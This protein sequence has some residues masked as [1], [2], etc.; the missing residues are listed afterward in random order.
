MPAKNRTSVRMRRV[1][2]ELRRLRID[3]KIPGQTV[4]RKLGVS[5]SKISRMENFGQG[6]TR[7]A[8][9]ELL[10]L[11]QAPRKLREGLL[12]LH[13]KADDPSLMD[14]EELPVNVDAENWIGLEQD[15]ATICNYENMLVPGLLQTFPYARAL[16]DVGEPRLSEQEKAD[17]T[18]AKIARQDL[19]RRRTPLRLQVV[20][21]E[22]ALRE[23]VGGTVVMRGQLTHLLEMSRRSGVDLRVLPFGRGGH[24]GL[25]GS[26]VIMDYHDL[27]S[28]VLLENKVSDLY[29]EEKGDVDTYRLYWQDIRALAHEPEESAALIKKIARTLRLAEKGSGRDDLAEEHI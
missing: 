27:P 8:L 2:L 14:R 1:M 6:L 7:D 22:A 17:R 23:I 26:F 9:I 19:L 10:T 12:R 21:H 24:A 25:S 18:N 13:E 3:A 28:L 15:A 5:A 16:F 11:Y 20:L 29:L 4:A